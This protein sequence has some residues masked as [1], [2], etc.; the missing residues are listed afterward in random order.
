[1][2]HRTRSAVACSAALLAIRCRV[3]ARSRSLRGPPRRAGKT[4]SA[5]T[6][7]S[8]T[9]RSRCRR[10]RVTPRGPTA[11]A[12]AVFAESPNR[13]FMLQRGEL[14]VIARPATRNLPDVGPSLQFP[15]FRC[16]CATRPSRA[17]PAAARPER[18]PRMGSRRGRRRAGA[19]ASTRAGSTASSCSTRPATSS[20]RG[21]SGTRC[22][23]GRTSSRISPYDPRQARLDRRRLSARDLQVHER[24]QEA[25]A[26][27]R[28]VQRARRRRVAFLPAHVHRVAAGRHVLR[29]GR[30]REHARREVRRERQVPRGL[31][32]EGHA[33]EATRGPAS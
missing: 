26:D 33:A 11:P 1:M 13:V 18:C 19:S 30:L 16:R 10:C 29:R 17:R 24:R 12:Q 32:R 22:S 31:G 4:C 28:H 8:P 21:R 5:R 7:S 6:R 14:P 15:V 25:R 2:P 3:S 9:G 23:R 20:R 27:D